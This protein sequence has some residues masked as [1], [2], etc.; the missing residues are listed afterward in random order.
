VGKIISSKRV[1]D[2]NKNANWLNFVKN[3]RADAEFQGL[4]FGHAAPCKRIKKKISNNE[5]RISNIEG[6]NSDQ[7]T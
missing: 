7:I 6:R 2:V 4:A 3:S 1:I 5:Y